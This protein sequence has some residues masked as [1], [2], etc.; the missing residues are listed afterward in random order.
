MR[1]A[2]PSLLV[3]TL[4]A[5]VVG[6]VPLGKYV[7]PPPSPEWVWAPCPTPWHLDALCG[8]IWIGDDGPP[9]LMPWRDMYRDAQDRQNY[10]RWL[11]D[12]T[13]TYGVR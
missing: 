9:P 10:H 7:A 11:Q 4:V 6:C 8:P 1:I 2:W 3:V 5:V 12:R 13:R